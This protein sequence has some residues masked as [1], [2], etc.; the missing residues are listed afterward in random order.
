M[1]NGHGGISTSAG[2][3]PNP[4]K[5]VIT[6]FTPMQLQELLYSPYTHSV[7]KKQFLILRSQGYILAE[8]L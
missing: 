5:Y 1:S 4:G 7:S 3:P 6:E 2:R 8:I